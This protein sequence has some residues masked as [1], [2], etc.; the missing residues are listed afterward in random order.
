MKMILAPIERAFIYLCWVQKLFWSDIKHRYDSDSSDV[1]WNQR[2]SWTGERLYRD[3]S[4]PFASLEELGAA[5]KKA[6]SEIS[7]ES[8][9]KSIEHFRT[10]LELVGS[11]DGG[12]IQH[13][14]RWLPSSPLPKRRIRTLLLK[15]LSHLCLISDQNKFLHSTEMNKCPFDWC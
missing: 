1:G 13:L 12:P 9:R 15:S 5:A 6:W 8:V 2:L 3:R 4:E 11:Q 14:A 7:M 10:R